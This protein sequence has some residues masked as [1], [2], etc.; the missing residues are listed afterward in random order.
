[1]GTRLRAN[2]PWYKLYLTPLQVASKS[3]NST[4]FARTLVTLFMLIPTDFNRCSTSSAVVQPSQWTS[5]SPCIIIRFKGKPRIIAH[6]QSNCY[7]A[8]CI[9]SRKSS[10]AGMENSSW[11]ESFLVM[12]DHFVG[13]NGSSDAANPAHLILFAE[14]AAKVS[15]ISN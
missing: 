8:N 10:S 15:H 2:E 4:L 9:T 13:P 11:E 14:N 3:A 1:M 5:I 12:K 6:A 7:H